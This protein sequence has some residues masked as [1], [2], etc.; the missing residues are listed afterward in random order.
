MEI[1]P[2][3]TIVQTWDNVGRHVGVCTQKFFK[4]NVIRGLNTIFIAE[5]IG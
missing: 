5:I 2:N 4:L 3:M 1:R